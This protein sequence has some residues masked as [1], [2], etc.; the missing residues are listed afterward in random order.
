M[1]LVLILG[2]IGFARAPIDSGVWVPDPVSGYGWLRSDRDVLGFLI[3]PDEQDDVRPYPDVP[4]DHWAYEA[5]M[6]LKRLGIMVGYPPSPTSR[7]R[8]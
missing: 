8:H 1:G 5:V 3:P 7:P 4:R 6:N 2:R